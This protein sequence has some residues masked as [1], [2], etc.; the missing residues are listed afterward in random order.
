MRITSKLFGSDFYQDYTKD[1]MDVFSKSKFILSPR[2]V[3]VGTYRTYEILRMEEIPVI[4][5][6][7][8]H[9]LPYYPR[10]NWC[11]FAILTTLQELPN[12][13]DK[14]RNIKDEDYIEMRNTLHDISKKYFQWDGVFEQIDMFFNSSNHSFSCSRGALT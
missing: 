5:T 10:L 11:K 7:K 14:L 13:T 2:G 3:A 1:W 8:F 9:W 12:I 6:D 4:V